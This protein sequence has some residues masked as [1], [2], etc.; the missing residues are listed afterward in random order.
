[1]GIYDCP[2]VRVRSEPNL[3]LQCLDMELSKCAIE[4]T[5]NSSMGTRSARCGM[6]AQPASSPYFASHLPRP[7]TPQAGLSAMPA[8]PRGFDRLLVVCQQCS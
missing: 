4:V 1:M 6:D 7:I 3:A 8:R 5:R 2:G